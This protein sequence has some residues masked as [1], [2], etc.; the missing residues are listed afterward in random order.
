MTISIRSRRGPVPVPRAV[1]ATAEP[2]AAVPG[3]QI[4]RRIATSGARILTTALVIIT[5]AVFLFLAVG[6]RFLGYQ[7]STM[8]TGSMSPLINPGDVVVSIKTPAAELKAGDIITYSIPVD[9]HRIE[10]HRVT[11]VSCRGDLGQRN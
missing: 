3:R 6:P 9:D 4:L 8:L 7:T 5:V 11:E 1:P 10:T 2:A